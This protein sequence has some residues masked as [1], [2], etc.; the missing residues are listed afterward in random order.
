M[1]P[2][3]RARPSERAN[4]SAGPAVTVEAAG[5]GGRSVGGPCAKARRVRETAEYPARG[6]VRPDV[7]RLRWGTTT[8]TN[9][10][11][12]EHYNSRRSRLCSSCEEVE[13]RT[14]TTT[15]SHRDARIS[16]R[17]QGSLVF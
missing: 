2:M 4:P 7:P 9:E 11:A 10:L 15:I 12:Q 6:R 5:R 3:A 8:G 17:D 13:S 14:I 1:M 16:C